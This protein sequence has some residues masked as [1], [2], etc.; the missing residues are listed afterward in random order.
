MPNGFNIA[1]RGQT[2][3]SDED[4]FPGC[5]ESL[6]REARSKAVGHEKPAQPTAL[7]PGT[8]RLGLYECVPGSC[9]PDKTPFLLTIVARRAL[10]AAS[11]PSVI[12]MQVSTRTAISMRFLALIKEGMQGTVVSG[13]APV[14]ATT[15]AELAKRSGS[16]GCRSPIPNR[17]ARGLPLRHSGRVSEPESSG[18]AGFR[19]V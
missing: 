11:G 19:P 9:D 8:R 12:C 15:L 5:C 13:L 10:S 4:H 18:A 2:C 6:V 16:H 7:P 1:D 14:F 3:S 17:F